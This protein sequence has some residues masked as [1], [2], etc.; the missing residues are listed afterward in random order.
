MLLS[1]NRTG[2][3]VSDRGYQWSPFDKLPLYCRPADAIANNE[4]S[5]PATKGPESN[6]DKCD[7]AI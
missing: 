3:P 7:I 4:L 6:P 1:V 2:R 5:L